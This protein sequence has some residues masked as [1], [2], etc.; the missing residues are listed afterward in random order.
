LKE[1]I[2]DQGKI[3]VWVSKWNARTVAG[4]FQKQTILTNL[5]VLNQSDTVFL[6]HCPSAE[7]K[8]K[9]WGHGI[10]Q[11]DCLYFL[12]ISSLIFEHESAKL[13]SLLYLNGQVI[14][15]NPAVSYC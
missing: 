11:F 14:T 6:T 13:E 1:S 3:L 4:R 10:S 5:G 7:K 12:G 9:Q 15:P 2:S 8:K